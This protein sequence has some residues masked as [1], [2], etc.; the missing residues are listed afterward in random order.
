MRFESKGQAFHERLREG[1][2]GIARSEPQRCAV[3]DAAGSLDAVEGR[4]WATIEDRL[5]VHG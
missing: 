3:I 2:L 4:V 5:A 1:F